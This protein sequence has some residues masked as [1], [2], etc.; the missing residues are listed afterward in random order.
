MTT[1][2]LIQSVKMLAIMKGSEVIAVTSTG[3]T[4]TFKSWESVVSFKK[5]EKGKMHDK[6]VCLFPLTFVFADS[7]DVTFTF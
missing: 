1:T 3:T 7:T 5:E 4:S 6:I 2:A